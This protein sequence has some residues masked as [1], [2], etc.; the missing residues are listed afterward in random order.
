MFMV[1]EKNGLV[2]SFKE[3]KKFTKKNKR[4][5]DLRREDE[6]IAVV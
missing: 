5:N 3:I 6:K 4:K 1:E 2:L